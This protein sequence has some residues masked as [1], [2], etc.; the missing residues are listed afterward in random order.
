MLRSGTGMFQ[1][2]YTVAYD[3]K[4]ETENPRGFQLSVL[5]IPTKPGWSRAIILGPSMDDPAKV[6]NAYT[7]E[8][9]TAHE[10][11][12]ATTNTKKK[13]K[14]NPLMKMIF[15]RI[16][17][18][19]VHQLSNRFLDSDLAFLHFQEQESQRHDSY[20]MP[21]ASD[22]CIAA[23]RSWVPKYTDVENDK[24]PAPLSR[25]AMFDRYSQHTSHCIHCQQG[26]KTLGQ[27]R[28]SAYAILAMSLLGFKY[29]IAKLTTLLCLGALRAVFKFEKSFREGEFKHYENH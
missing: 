15:K 5:C 9:D 24:L 16:P 28:K 21:A 11:A 7:N 25:S 19:F 26:L 10:D 2:P 23:L 27:V 14:G 17:V 18:W 3:A 1:A 29:K 12:K 8:N 13:R 22:R 4:Y 20:F 6:K